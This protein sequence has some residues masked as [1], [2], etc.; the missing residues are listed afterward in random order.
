MGFKGKAGVEGGQNS[1]LLAFRF[2]KRYPGCYH[3]D[4]LKIPHTGDKESLDRYNFGEVV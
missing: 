3:D 4:L 1:S 2:L